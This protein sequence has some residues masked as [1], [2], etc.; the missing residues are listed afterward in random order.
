MSDDLAKRLRGSAV[1]AKR[2][3]L[4]SYAEDLFQ[5]AA[6]LEAKDARIKEVER[7]LER[8]DKI[9]NNAMDKAYAERDAALRRAEEAERDA[10]RYRWLRD[11]VCDYR[12]QRMELWIHEFLGPIA[13][14]GD[15]D[16]AID[17][18]IAAQEQP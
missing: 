6:A 4:G 13:R 10:R 1:D 17:A 2:S 3:R 5:A 12:P 9:W 16:A 14:G 11:V 7:N 18:A 15:V 8:S